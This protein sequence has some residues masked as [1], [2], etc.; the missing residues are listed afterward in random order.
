MWL[1]RYQR[2]DIADHSLSDPFK[3]R[4]DRNIDPKYWMEIRKLPGG[5]ELEIEGA[6]ARRDADGVA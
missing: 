5:S 4:D 2:I 3:P 1:F 6:R